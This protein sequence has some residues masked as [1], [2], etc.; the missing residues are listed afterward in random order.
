MDDICSNQSATVHLESNKG[1]I[2]VKSNG[3]YGIL[4]TYGYEVLPIKYQKIIWIS[5][6]RIIICMGGKYGLADTKGDL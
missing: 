6:D 2:I 4:S 3:N 5:K 1:L